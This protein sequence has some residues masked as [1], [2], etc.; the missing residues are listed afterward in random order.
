MKAL[1]G[2]LLLAA[3]ILLVSGF[4]SIHASWYYQAVQA[5]NRLGQG[6]G[7][8]GVAAAR[9]S[10]FLDTDAFLWNTFALQVAS[11]KTFRVRRTDLDNHP[12]GREVH[13]SSGYVWLLAGA[14]R[15]VRLLNGDD[16]RTALERTSLVV[17]PAL[18]ILTILTAAVAVAR[19]GGWAAAT[20]L[21]LAAGGSAPLQA[22]FFPARPDHHS[23]AVAAAMGTILCIV[24]GGGGFVRDH[25]S[26]E[27]LAAGDWYSF[28]DEKRARFWFGASA[29]CAGVGMWVSAISLA[30]V[31]LGIGVGALL[32]MAFCDAEAHDSRLAYLPGLWRRWG[33]WGA[34]VSGG[35]YL[36]EYAPDNF[37][38][39][40]EVNHPLY[41]LAWWGGAQLLATFGAWRAS[42]ER[43]GRDRRAMFTLV[44][45]TAGLLALPLC[46]WWGGARF[47]R[48]LEPLLW[49]WHQGIF[50]F[51]PSRIRPFLGDFGLLLAAA[52]FAV[53][54][55]AGR[56]QQRERLALAVF[57]LGTALVP[58]LLALWQQRWKPFL[59]AALVVAPLAILALGEE[60]A[61]GG[62]WANRRRRSL[63]V[64][65]LLLLQFCQHSYR[66][67]HSAS[68]IKTLK[69]SSLVLASYAAA[70]EAAEYLRKIEGSGRLV[71]LSPSWP[72][73][74]I[75]YAV[76]AHG[77]GSLYWENVDGL[78]AVLDI[79]TEPSDT[80]A[81]ELIRERGV[82]HIVLMGSDY[83]P[84]NTY[85][86]KFGV[87]DPAATAKTFETRL[88]TGPRPGWATLMGYRS[89]V[90][91]FLQNPVFFKVVIF[92]VSARGA[93]P[94]GAA[95]PG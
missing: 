23:L 26:A 41:G 86:K 73:T 52:I 20:A 90:P 40:L 82:T 70:R 81:L 94:P 35:F 33:A 39:R 12:Y 58:L 43:P 67:L 22:A 71:I 84:A 63:A 42:R 16:L 75:S 48:P 92:R 32:S 76:D 74:I 55:L 14:G 3:A 80:R 69:S 15:F 11:G 24:L 61:P 72:S 60:R 34:A 46:V 30:L 37:G 10:I 38:M 18:F 50:E 79:L 88:V 62:V 13:W 36:L 4:V 49:R 1:R 87:S 89:S 7:S 93:S 45:A 19:R 2:R 21:V 8:P 51:M 59:A 17:N 53:A 65:L 66:E 28:P 47:Y 54:L 85:F 9:R 68:D 27:R 77:I 57:V 31:L 29:V 78:R 95:G 44:A 83:N 25:A 56:K 6:A 5:Y 64:L 91:L